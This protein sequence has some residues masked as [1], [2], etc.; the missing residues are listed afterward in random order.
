PVPGLRGIPVA[1]LLEQP[2]LRIDADGATVV[3][4]GADFR[5]AV[6]DVQEL[7]R[8][9]DAVGG[10]CGGIS[11]SVG[12]MGSVNAGQDFLLDGHGRLPQWPI[13]CSTASGLSC[14]AKRSTMV[15]LASLRPNTSTRVPSRRNLTTTL[16]SAL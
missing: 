3:F 8:S 6:D 9:L 15:A 7:K 10:P 16:S 5:M 2:L 13:N 11:N 1:Q 14:T 12:V 4:A